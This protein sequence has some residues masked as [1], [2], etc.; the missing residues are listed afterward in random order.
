MKQIN[1]NLV[2]WI[3]SA[4]GALAIALSIVV[5]LPTLSKANQPA[6]TCTA[7]CGG[8]RTVTCN[9][10]ECSAVDGAGCTYSDSTG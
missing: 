1:S 3:L 2:T 6:A 4:V 9:G 10:P 8:G 7:D 5:S